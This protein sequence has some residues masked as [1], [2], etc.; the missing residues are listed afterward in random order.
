MVDYS[1]S[2]TADGEIFVDDDNGFVASYIIVNPQT[3]EKKWFPKI[4]FDVYDMRDRLLTVEPE[5]A[6]HLYEVAKEAIAT[7]CAPAA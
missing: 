3:K 1:V 2:R 7:S 5:E 6:A 4:M